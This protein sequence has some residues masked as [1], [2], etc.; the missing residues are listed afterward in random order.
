MAVGRGIPLFWLSTQPALKGSGNECAA[1]GGYIRNAPTFRWPV[2]GRVTANFGSKT[3]GGASD[4]IDLAVP[5]GTAVRASDD[6]VVAYA[7]NELKGY[8][9]LVLIRHAN[10]FVTAYANASEISVKR[11]DQVHRGQVIAKSGQTAGGDPAAPFRDPQELGPGRPDAVPAVGQDRIGA[12]QLTRH[13]GAPRSTTGSEAQVGCATAV[14]RPIACAKSR[15]A[16]AHAA[17]PSQ[18]DF[19]HPTNL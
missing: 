11:N 6:G 19:A 14:P 13:S 2:R 1:L 5:E 12:G 10:G 15:S 18:R 17:R 9:D 4:G 3:V 16:V 8:G 7:G